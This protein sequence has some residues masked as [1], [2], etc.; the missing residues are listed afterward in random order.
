MA[1]QFSDGIEYIVPEVR[2]AFSCQNRGYGYYADVA[3]NCQIFHVC[4]PPDQH[5]SFF[6]PNQT[7]FDQRLLVCQDQTT[8]T[9]C[10]EAERYYVINENFGV[11]D[12]EKIIYF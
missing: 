1:Y 7:I 2:I 3:N 5:F 11:L 4:S 6:C 9:A 8:A 10:S 12:P